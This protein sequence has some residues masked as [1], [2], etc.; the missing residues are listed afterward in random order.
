MSLA[1]D[2]RTRCESLGI[3]L[4][5]Q[6]ELSGNLDQFE[7]DLIAG[8]EAGAS[9][10]RC[11]CLLQRRYEHFTSRAEWERWQSNAIATL[12]RVEP[13][14]A[15]HRVQL[16]VENHKDWCAAEQAE[17]FQNLSSQWIG[18]CLDF[19]NNLALL[20]DPIEVARTLS[21]W[22]LSTHVK[23]MK[24]RVTPD[25]FLL[26]EVP[27]GQGILDLPALIRICRAANP[28]V[29]FL[30]E[31]ITRDPLP[32]PCLTDQFWSTFPFSLAEKES[33]L[34]RTLARGQAQGLLLP[35]ENQLSDAAALALE[36]QLVAESLSFLV[37]G[38]SLMNQE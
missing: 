10:F 15:R 16:A 29:R 32:I 35:Q 21:P 25:G 23:D 19:G 33:R 12:Q 14:L 18:I 5:G 28:R 13:I 9:I 31:M 17:V 30:L 3:E 26:S 6:I 36:Q 34:Q 1:K 7:R 2:V 11:Y 24:L 38:P 4:E 20:E 27:L 37:P 8:K 22:I